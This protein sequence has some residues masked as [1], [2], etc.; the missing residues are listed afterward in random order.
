[1]HNISPTHTR[2]KP[3]LYQICKEVIKLRELRRKALLEGL[4]VGFVPTMGALH[5]GHLAL[6][7]QAAKENNRVYVSI[8]VNPTQFGV[9]EDLA[10]YP[11]TWASDLEKLTALCEELNQDKDMGQITTVFA[12]TS[13]EMYPNLPPTSEIDGDGTFVNVTPLSSALEGAS[14]P[15]FFRGVATVVMKL[16]NIVQPEKVY[17]GQK[18]IQQTFVVRRMVEDFHL[19]TEIRVGPTVR[20]YDGLA[21]SSRNVYLGARRRAVATVLLKA[22]VNVQTAFAD[23]KRDRKGLIIAAYSLLTNALKEQRSLLPKERALFEIDYISLADPKTLEEL[24]IV[25]P[26]EGAILSGAIRMLPIEDPQEWED[27]GLG[28]GT[29]PVRLIDNIKLDIFSSRMHIIPESDGSWMGLTTQTGPGGRGRRLVNRSLD[30]SAGKL[31]DQ[32]NDDDSAEGQDR[33]TRQERR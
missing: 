20:E 14:R 11:R 25:N 28:G 33:A 27:T 4:T 2:S 29:K 9:N 6:V 30:R 32:T 17:F 23:N 10:S 15:V 16:L 3:K 22:L 21:L 24:D 12:P 18:D 19:N 26:V 31:D 1:M 5:E 13:K 8:Y 7:R